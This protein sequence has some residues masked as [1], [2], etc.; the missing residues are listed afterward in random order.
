MMALM[1]IDDDRGLGWGRNAA[2][3][4]LH[5]RSGVENA[6]SRADQVHGGDFLPAIYAQTPTEEPHRYIRA[7]VH[8]IGQAIDVDRFEQRKLGHKPIRNSHFHCCYFPTVPLPVAN[9]RKRT[10]EKTAACEISTTFSSSIGGLTDSEMWNGRAFYGA[11]SPTEGR[12][13]CPRSRRFL[14]QRS[15]KSHHSG[16]PIIAPVMI[17]KISVSSISVRV[18]G[19]VSCVVC[20]SRGLRRRQKSSARLCKAMHDCAIRTSESSARLFGQLKPQKAL[21]QSL[22]VLC[23]LPLTKYRASAILRLNRC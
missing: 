10:F 5:E 14:F 18:R 1:Q 4:D 9:V 3:D 7:Q 19:D 20:T 17:S 8:D 23:A 13:G 21:R 11:S 22:A 16:A 2:L 15:H 6:A 12:G